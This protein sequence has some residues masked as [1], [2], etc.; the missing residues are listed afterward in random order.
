M[1]NVAVIDLG[2]NTFHILIVT[3]GKLGKFDIIYRERRYVYLGGQGID[4]I[5][6]ESF[7]RGI[8]TLQY[9]STILSKFEIAD[10]KAIGTA[11][12]RSAK[13]GKEFVDAANE[14]TGINISIITGDQEAIYIAKGISRIYPKQRPHLIM[15]IGGGSVEFIIGSTQIDWHQ[16]FDIGISVLYQRFMRSDPI[17]SDDLK[18]MHLYLAD[19]LKPLKE[20]LKQYPSYDLI[21]A[22][23][24]FEVLASHQNRPTDLPLQLLESNLIRHL[25]TQVLSL[26]RS[27]RIEIDGIPSHR[28]Q[29]LVVALAL[30]MATVDLINLDEV[31]VSSYSLKEGVLLD[32]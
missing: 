9:F 12:L 20:A 14:K 27:Q 32:F 16:S 19:Q 17:Y 24:T 4:E 28:G 21:G 23:G 2:T 3:L 1:S 13:N 30:I 31:Y 26:D 22:A 15:D 18:A 11:A 25:Y 29:Y 7:Q 8:E 10:V 5:G 6:P